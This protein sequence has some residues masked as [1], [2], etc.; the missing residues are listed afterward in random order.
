[1]QMTTPGTGRRLSSWLLRHF[2]P[3]AS[4]PW[5]YI[6]RWLALFVLLLGWGLTAQLYVHEGDKA[7]RQLNGKFDA[8]AIQS[9]ALI[10]HRMQ[11]YEQVLLGAQSLFAASGRVGRNEFRDY[12]AGLNL[13][14]HY[15]G[16]QGVGYA[17][18]I[19][20]GLINKHI[21][22]LR[23][24]GYANFDIH[25]DG[26]RDVYTSVIFLEPFDDRNRQA[27][28][29]DMYSDRLTPRIGDSAPGLRYSA[30]QQARDSGKAVISGKVRLVMENTAG[31][32]AENSVESRAPSQSGF[33]MYLPVYK[34][35]M[36]S[37][38]IAER[39]A[40][41]IGWVYSPFRMDNLMAGIIAERSSEIGMTIYDGAKMTEAMQMYR[42][43]SAQSHASGSSNSSG[44]SA[45][46][47]LLPTS[48]S[49]SVRIAGRSWTVAFWPLPGFGAEIETRMPQ[50]IGAIGV[51]MSIL[52]ALL[53]WLLAH[54]RTRAMQITS[55][56]RYE[57]EQRQ[58]LQN[59]LDQAEVFSRATID[60]ISEHICVIDDDGIVLASNA[61]WIASNDPYDP[62]ANCRIGDNYLS[63]CALKFSTDEHAYV[64]FEQGVAA[65]MRQEQDSF[66][67]ELVS[68]PKHAGRWFLLTVTR[69]PGDLHKMVVAQEDISVRKNG[70]ESLRL[71]ALVFQNIDEAVMVSDAH[72]NIIA[73]NPAFTKI[74]G[75]APHEV[76]G[77]NPK[78][79]QSGR[80]DKFFYNEMWR[81]LNHTGRWQ[82]EI[83][84]RN[85][86]GEL[87]AEW[88]SIN[89]ICDKDG[90]VDRYVAV[91]SDITEK[92]RMDKLI[93]NQAH[94]DTLTALPNRRLFVDNLHLEISKSEKSEASF[95]LFFID[96]DHF[97]EVNDTL[98]HHVGDK[99][100]VDAAQR[101]SSCLKENDTVGRL[102]GDEFTVLLTE[103]S[104]AMQIEH[105][106]QQ[107]LDRLSEPFVIG[108]ERVYV[109][110]SIGIT[111]YPVDALEL[112]S[113]FKN[114]DQALYVAKNAGRNQ[115]SYFT[116][117]MQ[118]SA[119]IRLQ[120]VND[121]RIALEQEQLKVF[122][123]PII[124]LS[125]NRVIKAEA[126]LRWF[127]PQRGMVSPAE[128]I[129][130]AEESGLINEIGD[131]VFTE[132][133]L[134]AQRWSKQLKHAFQISVNKSPVQFHAKA[135]YA[136]WPDYLKKLG[137]P[138]SSICVEITEGLLLNAAVGV[139]DQLQQYRDA[140]IQV[141]ID[142]FGTGYSSMAYLKKFNIDYL[143]IDQSFVRDMASNEVDR[144]IAEA[145]IVMAHKLGYKV[146]AEGIETVAQKNLLMAA[147]CDFG[148]GYLF[149]KAIPPSEF[150]SRFIRQEQG[151]LVA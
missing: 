97:K 146:I 24:E 19:P 5:R 44:M 136:S 30:M 62:S 70:E 130:L 18:I 34:K 148:Q 17:K 111:M 25:P 6:D 21:A 132:S 2:S 41:I 92:K 112:S 69:F 28:G 109:S 52:L 38:T 35:G 147:G 71:A 106:A 72:S 9:N 95:A 13:D 45:M 29:Y 149:S 36:P 27:F 84:N 105:I 46:V 59:A 49:K 128:F 16:I 110:A 125:T 122:F 121:L 23:S 33:L 141:S 65:L 31:N 53:M 7:A 144:A 14:Q 76:I 1:M 82:G 26:V 60:A 88:F 39:R 80:H 64:L 138:G 61:A 32:V 22:E 42:S 66:S 99:L 140:G 79:L 117:V 75:Y 63:Q 67:V 3:Q 83:W 129:P 93:W 134:W 15:P 98:G 8:L 48:L 58:Q 73:I 133:A 56:I 55:E 143:K 123:Q 127:H 87:I 142:D 94:F 96:L 4:G 40:N 137:L 54:G 100:L 74:T 86:N 115:Y 89:A 81:C 20:P 113:L 101:I 37:N 114:A 77:K 116:K 43:G 104:E 108:G 85:K 119:Q 124:E 118:Q 139:N 126:L 11:I 50:V 91:F 57:L 68:G 90:V 10:V 51:S 120:T 103:V 135:K 145:I 12:V 107:I 78:I 47:S 131:W 150:E 151:Q 102:G